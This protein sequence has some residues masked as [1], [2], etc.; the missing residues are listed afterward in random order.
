MGVTLAEANSIAHCAFTKETANAHDRHGK[1]AAASLRPHT[2]ITR[3]TLA[4]SGEMRRI[5]WSH[6][7]Q[8]SLQTEHEVEV[9]PYDCKVRRGI[10]PGRRG[11]RALGR[12]FERA[13]SGKKP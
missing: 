10:S 1:T 4:K 12:S 6:G 9:K 13:L 2:S 3:L 8:L 7:D 11:I 5:P